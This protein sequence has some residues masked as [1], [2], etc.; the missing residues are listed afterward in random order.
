[1]TTDASDCLNDF[2]LRDGLY[3]PPTKDSAG[4]PCNLIDLL[5]GN[6]PFQSRA[7]PVK[8]QPI[9]QCCNL[10]P[11]PD[12]PQSP[13]NTDRGPGVENVENFW[14][15]DQIAYRPEN[16]HITVMAVSASGVWKDPY[17]VTHWDCAICGKSFD[18][19]RE[20][21]TFKFLNKLTWKVPL[22]TLD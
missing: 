12:T 1:M 11:I 8:E 4:P 21:F 19:I 17:L 22:T 14:S 7:Q 9:D 2:S 6:K 16:V 3:G 5:L 10:P 20:D 13:P 18:T 15:H